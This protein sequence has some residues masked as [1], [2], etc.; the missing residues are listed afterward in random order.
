VSSAHKDCGT[1]IQKEKETD[2]PVILK[3]VTCPYCGIELTKETQ[4]KEHV[5][6][7]R[8]VPKGT[9]NNC[10]NI[11][12]F[13]CTP[14]NNLK[15]DLEDDI[16]AI[17]LYNSLQHGSPDVKLQQLVAHKA[18]MSRSRKTKKLIYDSHEHLQV[19]GKLFEI[20]DFNCQF[21][22]PPQIDIQRAFKLATLHL[23][24]LF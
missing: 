12:L 4:S 2:E 3:N 6:G 21:L 16:S 13:A 15:S 1:T 11:R 9:L 5:I 8:F 14:C 19:S 20:A 22:A 23:Q 24:A 10:T 18:Q 17:S 7:R